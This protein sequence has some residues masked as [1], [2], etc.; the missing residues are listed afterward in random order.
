MYLPK[1]GNIFMCKFNSKSCFI[2]RMFRNGMCR[3]QNK[4]QSPS[5]VTSAPP[6]V[7]DTVEDNTAYQELGQ[8]NQASH[9]NQLQT[10][11]QIVN[12]VAAL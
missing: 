10:P 6:S 11:N 9:Y 12:D 2:F 5:D 7:Y 8:V 4:R 1:F 3:S